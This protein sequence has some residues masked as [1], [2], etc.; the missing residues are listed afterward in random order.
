MMKKWLHNLIYLFFFLLPWQVV[1]L[2][3][4][5]EISGVKWQYGTMGIYMTEILLWVI[6]LLALARWI[7]E[8]GQVKYKRLSK[9]KALAL[10]SFGGFLLWSAISVF[11]SEQNVVSWYVWIKLLEATAL[12]LVVVTEEIKWNKLAFVILLSGGAQSLLAFIQ[13][14]T[15]T[16][17]GSSILGMSNQLAQNAGAIVMEVGGARYLR[18]YGSLMHPNIL[19]G[20]LVVVLMIGAWQYTLESSRG[21]KQVILFLSLLNLLGLVLTFSRSAV[22]AGLIG[23]VILSFNFLNKKTSKEIKLEFKKWLL[24]MLLLSLALGVIFWPFL[25]SRGDLHN[26]LENISVAQRVDSVKEA[27]KLIV[28]EA[29]KG[30]GLGNYTWQVLKNNNFKQPWLAQPVH[31]I[32]LLVTAE[33]GLIGLGLFLVWQLTMLVY[34]IKNKNFLA[35]SFLV[36]FLTVS[37]F[38]HYWLT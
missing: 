1:W 32:W 25:W 18:A 20:F 36:I 6:L 19:G 9:L 23:L 21:K 8:R 12:V 24:A 4:V 35:L 5:P 2:I 27:D 37:V 7:K 15:Q 31:N 3:S 33:L 26:R 38:D 16:V 13:F 28:R 34:Y 30:V 11:W 22:L 14:M 17:F 29:F 10:G